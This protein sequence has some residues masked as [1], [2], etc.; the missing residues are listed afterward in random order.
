MSQ[1]LSVAVLVVCVLLLLTHF[2]EIKNSHKRNE[3]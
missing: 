1:I 2:I 3:G